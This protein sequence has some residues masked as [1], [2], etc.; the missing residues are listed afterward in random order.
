M[1]FELSSN[2]QDAGLWGE[3]IVVQIHATQ[4][5]V[6]VTR[7]AQLVERATVNRIRGGSNPSV[8]AAPVV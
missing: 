3:E 4:L 2:R 6:D 8:G 5:C 7:V 1:L